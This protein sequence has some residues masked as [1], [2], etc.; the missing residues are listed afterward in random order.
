MVARFSKRSVVTFT[1]F[2]TIRSIPA[3]F[4]WRMSDSNKALV[5]QS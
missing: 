5:D 3:A 1:E 2:R 4:R